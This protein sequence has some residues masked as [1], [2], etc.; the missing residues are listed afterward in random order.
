MPPYW[1]AQPRVDPEGL[2]ADDLLL[3]VAHRAR[4]VHHVDDDR[5]RLRLRHDDLAGAVA[6]VLAD[7]DDARTDRDRTAPVVIWRFSAAR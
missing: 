1:R 3:L 6:L 7:R 5:V 4:H 2:A